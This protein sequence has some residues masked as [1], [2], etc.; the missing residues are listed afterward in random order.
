MPTYLCACVFIATD[1]RFI[2]LDVGF[3]EGLTTIDLGVVIG[4]T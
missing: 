3:V 4:H 1:L 2:L